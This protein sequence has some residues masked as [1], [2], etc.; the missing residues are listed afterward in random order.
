MKRLMLLLQPGTNGRM[1]PWGRRVMLAAAIFA[2]CMSLIFSPQKKLH[3]QTVCE[4]CSCVDDAEQVMADLLNWEMRFSMAWIGGHMNWLRDMFIMNYWWPEHVQKGM[5]MVTDQLT[6]VAMTEMM[7]IGAMLDAKHTLE[8]ERLFQER[9][10]QAH[11]DYRSDLDMCGYATIVQNME[12]NN[13]DVNLIAHLLEQR[14]QRRQIHNENG[15]GADS[16]TQD[17]RERMNNFRQR[18]CDVRDNNYSGGN[19]GLQPLCQN[20]SP[21]AMVNRDVDFTRTVYAKMILPQFKFASQTDDEMAVWALSENL[22]G[23][24]TFRTIPKAYLARESNQGAVLDIRSV[25]AKRS[26]AEYSFQTMVGMRSEY[27]AENMQAGVIAVWPNDYTMGT[28]NGTGNY[29]RSILNRQGMGGESGDI[30]PG[31]GSYYSTMY[32]LTKAMYQD[33]QFYV[34]LYDSPS[35][36]ERK[37]IVM[38]GV[39][40]MQSM[41]MLKSRLRSEMLLAVL[42]EMEIIKAQRAVQDKLD[43]ARTEGGGK[44]R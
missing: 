32:A 5:R 27:Q 7:V 2:L 9:A 17:I 15:S 41:D 16:R 37:S 21:A 20:S 23:N 40:L 13:R 43:Q 10:A 12:Q 36:L 35:N 4:L 25:I 30:L 1:L 19:S 42:T 33:P 8:T 6:D 38:R 34:G 44:G 22:Y 26:V 28:Y 18:F 39:D 11:K 24:N 3:A 14:S 29:I 31:E